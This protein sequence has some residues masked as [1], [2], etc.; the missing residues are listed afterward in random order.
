MTIDAA[1]D[2]TALLKLCRQRNQ[3]CW[4][5]P[6]HRGWTLEEHRRLQ[7][8]VGR[9]AAKRVTAAQLRGEAVIYYPPKERGSWAANPARRRIQQRVESG[10]A[11][12]PLATWTPGECCEFLALVDAFIGE[13]RAAA[14]V[15][16]AASSC[17]AVV[18]FR[19]GFGR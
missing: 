11:V 2:N 9:T 12:A 13:R 17:G 15:S 5:L 16:E 6:P 18:Q 19:L 7:E 4:S 1:F 14:A 3:D 8:L 10:L